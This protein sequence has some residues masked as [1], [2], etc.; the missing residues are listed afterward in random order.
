MSALDF[1]VA[2]VDEL[3][4]K[5]GEKER[6]A[7]AAAVKA[8][9]R[10]AHVLEGAIKLHIR[11]NPH[12]LVR[13]DRRG[14]SFHEGIIDTGHLLNSV[15]VTPIRGGAEV[16]PHAEYAAYL[17][18]GR[19]GSSAAGSEEGVAGHVSGMRAFPFVQPAVDE[20]RAEVEK[21]VRDAIARE[22]ER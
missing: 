12:M 7:S 22:T 11:H 2:G 20:K 9:V 10:G 8:C 17:E 19:A 5:L 13:P 14:Q 15:T 16:G 1:K 18:Y 4:R 3:V 6:R 21:M